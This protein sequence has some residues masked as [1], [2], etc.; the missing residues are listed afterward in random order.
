MSDN[1]ALPIPTLP[2]IP[3][4][5]QS[6][7]VVSLRVRPLGVSHLCFETDGIL[8]DL[9][10]S[11]NP[12]SIGLLGAIVKPFDFDLFYEILGSRPTQPATGSIA[13]SLNPPG[14]GTA[15]IGLGGTQWT[16][17]S[18]L[19]G[20]NQLKIGANL[21]ET[22]TNAANTLQNS[23]DPNTRKFLL[24]AT[25]TALNLTAATSGKAGNALTITAFV[26][27]ARPSG[28]TLSG[29]DPSRL[30]YDFPAIQSF[31]SPFT[32]A[33]LRTEPRKAALNKAINT[34]QNAFFAK[35]A[36]KDAI[37]AKA[38]QDYFNP[39]DLI[40]PG[41]PNPVSKSARLATLSDTNE[42]MWTAL[43]NAYKAKGMDRVGSVVVGTVGT[44]TSDIASFGYQAT[45]SNTDDTSI[46]GTAKPEELSLDQPPTP[47]DP[48]QPLPAWPPAPAPNV[49]QLDPPPSTASSFDKWSPSI[50]GGN[51]VSK[52]Y[53][54]S[55]SYQTNSNAGLAHQDQTVTH[56]D[57][58]FRHPYY[59][60]EARYQ[61]AQISLVDQQFATF[62]YA[63]NLPNLG[64]VFDN[65]LSVIDADVYRLQIAFLN[66]IL[67]SPIP[68]I[69][70]GVYKNPGEAVKAGE[71]VIRV[72]NF[73]VILIEAIVVFRGVII[74]NKTKATITSA[75][76]GSSLGSPTTITGLVV[77]ARGHGNDDTWQLVIECNNMDQNNP[78]QPIFP[79]GYRFDI[80]DT[81]VKFS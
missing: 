15:N 62:M 58:V 28:P 39:G 42:S 44:L 67:M 70:T 46:S 3:L 54:R 22:L 66:T 79:L 12:N 26:P 18:T 9:N 13:F 47:P 74:A 75:L 14:D 43:S 48:W 68:G 30:Q 23:T 57:Q 56:S 38:N 8:G 27:G 51:A 65:E 72:E 34:R 6:A 19:T 52:S 61:R 80:D 5:P 55:T 17:V 25:A 20:G 59:E 71:T 60:A 49:E 69:V 33:T 37:I 4:A 78:S 31:V 41:T 40:P 73:A 11:L 53:Q 29:A 35:Y 77:A 21:A 36:N 7:K 50:S 76:F 24:S 45:S 2:N 32:L 64:T 16:F 1:S 81:Q 10:L 63:Q